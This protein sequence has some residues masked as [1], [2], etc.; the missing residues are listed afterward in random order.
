[1]SFAEFGSREEGQ[2][3]KRSM[4]IEHVFVSRLHVAR[5]HAGDVMIVRRGETVSWLD[6]S[7]DV[8]ARLAMDLL[9]AADID[10]LALAQ[11]FMVLAEKKDVMCHDV[12]KWRAK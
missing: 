11:H 7:R 4:S 5:N 9:D 8:A 1:M 10:K 6:M 3:D 12:V 2:K